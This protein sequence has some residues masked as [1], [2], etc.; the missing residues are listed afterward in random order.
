MS[1]VIT[2][3]VKRF[4][5]TVT[6]YEPL[7]L[8][9]AEAIGDARRSFADFKAGDTVSYLELDKRYLSAVFACVEKWELQ[10]IPTSPTAETL[11]MSP[12]SA[13]HKLIEWLWGEITAIYDEEDEIPNA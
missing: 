4:P 9:Q 7:L 12:Q 13:R 2:S 11:P 3:P 8:P 10:N 6:L 1:K 5:G